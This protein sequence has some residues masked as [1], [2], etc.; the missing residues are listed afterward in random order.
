MIFERLQM[1]RSIKLT[2]WKIRLLFYA[3][4]IILIAPKYC[5]SIERRLNPQ[6]DLN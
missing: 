6:R 5:G 4:A 2:F 1:Q 3:G